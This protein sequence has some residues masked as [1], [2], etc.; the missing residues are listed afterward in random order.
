MSVRASLYVQPETMVDRGS[1]PAAFRPGGN[2]ALTTLTLSC[3]I[4]EGKLMY[5]QKR[6]GHFTDNKDTWSLWQ[7]IQTL[8]DYKPPSHRSAMPP[9]QICSVTSM[10]GLMHWKTPPPHSDQVLCMSSVSVKRTISR[11]N[12]CKAAGPDSILGHVLRHCAEQ[13]KDVLSVFSLF[14]LSW[15]KNLSQQ[16]TASTPRLSGYW[17]H[18]MLAITVHTLM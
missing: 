12:L 6:N 3:G 10:H 7:G 9:S 16:T 2:V 1:P 18:C 4:R 13:L 11:I 5:S 14:L 8:T 17:M 15:K